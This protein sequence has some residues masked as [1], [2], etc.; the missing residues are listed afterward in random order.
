[1][2]PL[3]AAAS[4]V[5][6]L[7]A[8]FAGVWVFAATISWFTGRDPDYR[9]GNYF[10]HELGGGASD[11]HSIECRPARESSPTKPSELFD[12]GIEAEK[13][14]EVAL[15]RGGFV[16]LVEGQHTLCFTVPRATFFSRELPRLVQVGRCLA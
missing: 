11:V 2:K 7:A 14:I 15:E 5:M 6:T 8:C 3:R 16:R 4:W 9:V 13:A 12:C 10:V 1:M